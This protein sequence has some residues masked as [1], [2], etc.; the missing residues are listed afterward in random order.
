MLKEKLMRLLPRLLIS[1]SL[2][3]VLNSCASTS[4]Q[5]VIIK[6]HPWTATE[7]SQIRDGIETLPNDSML[8]SVLEDYQRVCANL[9]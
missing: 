8:I 1:L 2:L 4:Q 9:K 5:P 6:C 7:K 3:A